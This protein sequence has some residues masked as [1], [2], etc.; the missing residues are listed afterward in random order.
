MAL[1]WILN[2]KAKS[3]LPFAAIPA[4]F[5]T[6][7]DEVLS[8]LDGYGCHIERNVNNL[9]RIVVD[10][11]GSTSGGGPHR[12]R[13]TVNDSD[14][15]KCDIE[16]GSWVL[17]GTAQTNPDTA[18]LGDTGNTYI[19]AT[20]THDTTASPVKPSAISIAAQAAAAPDSLYTTKRNICKINYDT[21]GAISDFERF[22]VGDIIQNVASFQD[23]DDS[24]KVLQ[25]SSNAMEF[26]TDIRYNDT[27]HTIEKK[28]RQCTIENG[29][30]SIGKE[31]GW[32]T[33]TTAS[34]C[35]DT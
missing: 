19:V 8:Q 18:S 28:F 5:Y 14:S 7:V 17:N 20:I 30:W 32:D 15:S 24:W 34:S 10:N 16:E 3:G 25:G 1:G 27:A 26:I 2:I 33:V 6:N 11:P 35:P 23:T 22:Q 21:G 31:Q 9:W 12:F 29:T 4:S 13:P